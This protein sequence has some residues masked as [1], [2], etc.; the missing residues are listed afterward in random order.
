MT[1][2]YRIVY[3]PAASEDLKDIYRYIA[4]EL[5]AGQTAKKQTERIRTEILSLRSF[6]ERY[7]LVDWEPWASLNMHKV[8]VDRY[9]VYYTVNRER[10]RVTIV[11]IFYGGRDVAQIIRETQEAER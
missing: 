6:P 10:R 8:P 1:D 11:R 3:S 9:V 4:Y 2:E 5:R 7:A